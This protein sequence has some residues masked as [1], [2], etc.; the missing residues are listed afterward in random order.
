QRQFRYVEDPEAMNLWQ[1]PM[2]IRIGTADG[3]STIKHLLIGETEIIPFASPIE[4]AIANGGGHGFYRVRYEADLLTA[5]QSRLVDLDPLERFTLLDDAWAF[6]IEGSVPV[7]E[8]AA[9]AAAFRDESEHAVWQMLSAHLLE[10]GRYVP[11]DDRYATFVRHLVGPTADRIGWEPADGEDDLTRRLRGQILT[12]LGR[13]GNDPA[14]IQ[15]ARDLLHE[16]IDDPAAADAE[17]ALAVLAISATFGDIDDYEA[18]VRAFEAS[19]NPQ[20]Q[21]R[22]LRA[23][24]YFPGLDVADRT[25]EMALDGRIRGQDAGWVIAG[26]LANQSTADHIWNRVSAQWEDLTDLLPPATQRYLV[27][28]L[29]AMVEPGLARRVEAFFSETGFPIAAKSLS[30]KL[31]LQQ[32]MVSLGT[33]EKDRLEAFLSA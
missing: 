23:L 12:T 11:D 26:L 9:L 24:T 5:V 32:A 25:F 21:I 31:E 30:Q 3:V 15:R 6:T 20:L 1:I 29:P 22:F 28:S 10:L 13:L 16:V 17:V 7:D 8:F 18:V 19:S 27:H 14:T 4:W 33:R 2:L